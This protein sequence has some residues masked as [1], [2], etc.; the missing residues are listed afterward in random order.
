MR[1]KFPQGKPLRP[2]DVAKLT[3]L[4]D[5]AERLQREWLAANT[6]Q[7]AAETKLE[8][9]H[10]SSDI[11]VVPAARDALHEARKTANDLRKA[12]DKAE[13]QLQA[14]MKKLKYYGR[15]NAAETFL[16]RLELERREK[17]NRES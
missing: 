8:L 6:A 7:K 17:R 14:R 5:E 2:K 15:L 11:S 12:A 13:R 10:K 16:H 1:L 9:A 4:D 3:E